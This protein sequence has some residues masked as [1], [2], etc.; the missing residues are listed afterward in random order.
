[1]PLIAAGVCRRHGKRKGSAVSEKITTCLW[2]DS[3]A[4][5]WRRRSRA[6]RPGHHR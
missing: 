2:F 6:R 3:Q 5:E 4:E 1:M